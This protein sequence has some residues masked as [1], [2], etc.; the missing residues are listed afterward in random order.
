MN[1]C[2][3]T[4]MFITAFTVKMLPSSAAM[5]S[6]YRETEIRI[7]LCHAAAM[8]V[9]QLAICLTVG[10]SARGS[11]ATC[12]GDKIRRIGVKCNHY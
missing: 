9:I 1:V 7:N 11:Q 12:T 3:R 6:T 8:A 4:G 10:S 5:V 2:T